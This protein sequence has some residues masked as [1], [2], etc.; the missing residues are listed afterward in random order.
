MAIIPHK[1]PHYQPNPATEIL[2]LG[3]FTPDVPG[4]PDFFYGRT[5]NFLWHLLPQAYGLAPL[6][7]ESLAQKQA[8][9]AQ[10]N[11]DFA[12]M[13]QSLDLPEGL[14]AEAE[15]DAA[16]AYVSEWNNVIAIIDA[17]PHL[18]AIYFTRKTFNGLPNVRA[19]ITPL[20]QHCRQKGIRFCKLETP[21]RH[22][23]ETK[24]QQWKDTIVAQTTC[25][26]P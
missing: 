25:L 10:H 22:Y 12:D 23:S 1:L 11:I 14:E 4:A 2:I 5:R 19:Q 26:R 6:K 24:L 3:T 16:D 13:M 21:A 18:K 8:F 15:D 7:D 17:L 20:A 9:M